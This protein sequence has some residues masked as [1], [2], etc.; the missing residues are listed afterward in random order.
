MKKPKKKRE[1]RPC[2]LAFKEKHTTQYF[3]ALTQE[4]FYEHCLEVLTNR[5]TDGWYH[6]PEEKDTQPEVPLEQIEQL[7]EGTIKKAAMKQY[8]SWERTRQYNKE[9]REDY[10][11]I[12]YAIE[13]QDGRQAFWS[14]DSR[15][16]CEYERMDRIYPEGELKLPS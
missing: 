10:G 1:Y 4:Q 9:A 7:P 11:L 14:L 13:K 8:K 15:S 12:E 16:D 5:F 6:C 2:V 3:W